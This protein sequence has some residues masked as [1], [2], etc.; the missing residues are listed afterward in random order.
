MVVGS[1]WSNWIL[2]HHHCGVGIAITVVIE[3]EAAT[4]DEDEEGEEGEKENYQGYDWN[5]LL[6][7]QFTKLHFPPTRPAESSQ[8][9]YCGGQ[10]LCF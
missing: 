5:W 8:S 10:S 6:D 3:T 4:E 7:I 1:H 9:L 2:L